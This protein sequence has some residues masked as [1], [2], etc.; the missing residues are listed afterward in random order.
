MKKFIFIDRDGT[1][2]SEPKDYQVDCMSKLSF[3]P[4]V[5]ISLLKLIRFGYQLILITNQDGLGGSN[6]PIKN[7]SIV[8]NFMLQVFLSQGI[9][10]KS[11]LICPH[12]IYDNCN[13]RKPNIGLVQY[14]IKNNVMDKENSYVIG[15]RNT[16]MKLA[17]NMGIHGLLYHPQLF[18]WLKITKLLTTFNRSAKIFRR[19]NETDILVKISLDQPMENYINTGI[20]FLNHM[21]DQICTHSGIYMYINAKG[22][23]KIDDHHTVEDIG[24]SLGLALKK[25]LGN[26]I[27]I[28][29]YGFTLPMD[30]SLSSCVLDISGRPYFSF[31]ADFKNRFIGDLSSCMVKHFFF[32]L[33]QS[34]EVS[35]H[36]HASGENDHHCVESIFKSFGRTLKQAILVQD[37]KLPTSKGLL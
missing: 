22:D 20:Y 27:G 33:A 36:I 25:S 16:D 3:E 31:K 4:Y 12:Y 19:T 9:L 24:I 30:E 14:W 5:I 15:D 23:L 17:K 34:M 11:I 6:F 8:Q 21:L 28:A 7:F 2:I 10:F 29:R 26:K 1:L 18:S 13:C 37:R 35:L 32:S